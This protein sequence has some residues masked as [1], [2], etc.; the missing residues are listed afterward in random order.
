MTIK[1]KKI[2]EDYINEAVDLVIKAHN[3]ERKVIDFLPEKNYLDMF[4]K[5]IN[6]LFENGLGVVTLIDNKLVGFLAGHEIKELWGK[7]KGIYCPLYGHG[8]IKRDRKKIYQQLYKKAAQNW[9]EKGITNHSITLY[10]QDKETIDTW[11]WMGFGLRCV[12]AIREVDR[13]NQEKS[14]INIKKARLNDVSS[15]ADIDR[16]HNSYYEESPIFMPVKVKDPISHL[17]ERLSKENHHMW[18]AYDNE[19]VIG[20][21]RIEP[22]GESFISEHQDVMN[23]T[24][25][26][27]EDTYRGKYVGTYLLDRIQQWLIDNKYKLCGVD[28]ESINITGSNFWNKYFT[29]YTYSLARRIDERI[30]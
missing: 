1:F 24:G 3:E 11:F 4:E 7:C 29:A 21:M 23:I 19:R 17:T 25:A 12:D 10:A 27:V 20:Y 8:A 14:E 5:R 6:N 15:L 22:N 26:Y 28:Y 16:K 2:S 9:V 13:I 18:I 30:I